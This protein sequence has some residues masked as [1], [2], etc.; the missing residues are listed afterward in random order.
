MDIIKSYKDLCIEIEIW[1][2]RVEAY[3]AEINALKKLAKA[4]GPGDVKGIDYT[5][6]RIQSTSQIGF[7]EFLLR[8]NKLENH[9]LLHE[10]TI[11]E[12][13]KSKLKI[14]EHLTS[15]EGLDHKVVYMR[16]IEGK[17]LVDIAKELGYSYDYIREISSNNKKPTITPHTERK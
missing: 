7:E 2:E 16:D 15:L 6:P 17:K 12:M 13:V 5:Q 4:Y 10:E 8:F 11:K 1:K 14:E 3:K 9:I